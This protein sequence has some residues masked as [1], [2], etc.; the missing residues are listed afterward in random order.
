MNSL[1]ITFNVVLA[2][3]MFGGG[4]Y[5]LGQDSFFLRDRW[6]PSTGT[7]FQGM[8]LYCLALGL[9]FLGAFGG[10]VGYAWAKGALPMPSESTIRPHPAY[11]GSV[12]ARFWYLVLPA[13]VLIMLAFFLAEKTPNKALQPTP[14]RGAA[15]LQR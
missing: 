13:V 9:F 6:D 10:M 3:A 15:Q 2:I 11:K 14:L 12:I 4:T 5:L 8:T 1:R 7:L